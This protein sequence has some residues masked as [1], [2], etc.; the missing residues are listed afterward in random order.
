VIGG[1]LLAAALANAGAV[2]APAQPLRARLSPQQITVGDPVRVQIEV[3]LPAGQRWGT[4]AIDPRLRQWGDAEVLASQRPHPVAGA[5]GRYRLELVVTAFRPGK[6]S[7]PPLPIAVAQPRREEAP[8]QPPLLFHT[9][10][11]SF[12]VRSVLPAQ[13][14]PT[15]RPPTPPQ[16]LPLGA[17]FW[18]AA[19]ALALACLLAAGALFWRRRGLALARAAAPSLPPFGQFLRELATLAAEP[20][21]ERVHTGMS[22]ALRHLVA[23]LLGFPAAE[24]TTTEIDHELRRGRLT[25]PL[26][27]RLL[28]LLRRCD[29]VKFA[30]VPVTRDTAR[31]RLATA[32]DIGEEIQRELV[33]AETE[34]GSR[35]SEAVA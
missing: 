32:R 13:G 4:P 16:P 7:L 11:L 22:L 17:A 27:R 19:G 29:E 26:R 5:P 25:A 12:D 20:S 23:A 35:Q 10:P 33:P 30:K 21:P 14:E 18:W 3:D 2:G 28:D 6:V 15:P 9:P 24:R 34:E 1:L 8:P 31:E